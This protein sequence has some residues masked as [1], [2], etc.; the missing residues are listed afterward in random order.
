LKQKEGIL[1]TSHCT[2]ESLEQKAK[3]IEQ[4]VEERLVDSFGV[5]YA[6]IHE[7][8]LLPWTEADIKP[9]DD[10]LLVEGFTTSE[11][12]NYENSGM[13]TGAYLAAQ[14]YCYRVT[15]DPMALKRAARSF[16]GLCHIYDIG[17]ELQEGYFPKTYGGRFSTEISSDQYLYA[18]KGMMAYLGV[19]PPEDEAAIRRM[20]PK[21]VDFWIERNY[22]HDYFGILDMQ[23]P[24][25]RFPSLLLAAYAVSGD[26]KYRA[27]A[28]RLNREHQVYL[29]PADSQILTRVKAN[30][31]F[32]ELEQQLGNAYLSPMIHECTA[33]D[34][35]E[36]DECLQHSD[37][38]QA[39]W[40]RSM[41][42]SWQEGKL[43]LVEGG[44][45]R[46]WTLYNPATGEASAPAPQYIGNE[47]DIEW[48][49]MHWLSGVLSSRTSMLARV[50]VHVAKWLPEENAAAT[51]QQLLTELPFEQMR[52]YVYTDKRDLPE[53]YRFLAKQ[54]DSDTI[55]NWLW[56][57]WQGRHEGVIPHAA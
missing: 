53:R 51:V 48:S 54:V 29:L 13:T 12:L 16:R 50:G 2:N 41:S 20:I 17:R 38:Y 44:L 35:M 8:T 37:S 33:M 47:S 57:Y 5:I 28:E 30:T 21:M 9:S 31:P 7:D 6:S 1:D 52:H 40:L 15:A 4:F 34:V 55:T 23:W 36:L 39:D 3:Q 32:S 18:I 26:E 45:A 46:F 10:Y 19:A 25:G 56:A 24:L 22:R 43:A 42:M 14:S 11:M 49:L 27:E